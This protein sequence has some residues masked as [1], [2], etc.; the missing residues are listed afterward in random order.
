ME[1]IHNTNSGQ[2][3]AMVPLNDS[4]CELVHSLDAGSFLFY[5]EI[6]KSIHHDS[7]RK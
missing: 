3:S 7:I 1:H 6:K 4:G 5:L 2:S